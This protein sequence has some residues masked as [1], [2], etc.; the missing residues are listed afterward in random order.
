MRRGEAHGPGWGART[1]PLASRSQAAGAWAP[2]AGCSGIAEPGVHPPLGQPTG[3][4]GGEWSGPNA[5]RET[6]GKLGR[7]ECAAPRILGRERS[8]AEVRGWGWGARKG[9]GKPQQGR[10]LGA[11]RR[12]MGWPQGQ[13]DRNCGKPR[14]WGRLDWSEEAERPCR[15]CFL[16]VLFN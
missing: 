15:Q 13:V 6:K 10:E 9:G 16:K 1:G 5:P 11:R 7:R 12:G 14:A 8:Q 3:T 2:V 4:P